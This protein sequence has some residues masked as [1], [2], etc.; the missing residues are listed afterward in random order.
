MTYTLDTHATQG[1]GTSAQEELDNVVRV[2]L[3]QVRV[4]LPHADHEHGLPGRVHHR[5]RSAD[6]RGAQ[7]G[8][9]HG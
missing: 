8:S 9:V 4:R 7:H 3:L 1:T 5:D 6:L 2:E